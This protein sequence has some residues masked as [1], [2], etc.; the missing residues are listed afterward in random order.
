MVLKGRK[1]MPNHKYYNELLVVF[2]K[3]VRAF[4]SIL[5]QK[6]ADRLDQIFTLKVLLFDMENELKKKY[7][8]WLANCVFPVVK[9]TP[10]KRE[11]FEGKIIKDIKVKYCLN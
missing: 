1:V 5:M 4:N 8:D 2:Y 3:Y 9:N 6:K 7:G 10:M 11:L